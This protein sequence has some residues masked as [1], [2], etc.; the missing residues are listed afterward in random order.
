[1]TTKWI[2]LSLLLCGLPLGALSACGGGA[3]GDDDDDA[4][5]SLCNGVQDVGEFSIDETFDVDGDG[6]FDADDPGCA[7]NYS[8]A[9][10]DCDDENSSVNPAATE[11][12][13]DGLNNDCDS[14]TAESSDTDMDGV[15]DCDGDCDDGRADTYPGAP[16][17]ECDGV[18]QDCDGF[19][20]G[21]G[22]A[23]NYAGTWNLNTD[24]SFACTGLEIDF[25]SFELNQSGQAVQID[26]DNCSGCNGPGPLTGEF[27]AKTQLTAD[28]G[29]S[30]A[31]QCDAVFSVLLTFLDSD[32][33]SG[34]LSV[35]FSGSECGSLGC[36][37]ALVSFA[38][39]KA[40]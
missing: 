30:I 25:A 7:A 1:M 17:V 13:C 39:D 23:F 15:T 5:N 38:G 14:S 32:S 12:H 22:C 20:A 24:V 28:G 40:D 2:G 34:S 10:L 21:D 9:E 26:T 29:Q 4:A 3:G 37:G 11:I 18:D 8:A 35:N 33:L 19:D 27:T 6:F 31:G 36:Q 16:E